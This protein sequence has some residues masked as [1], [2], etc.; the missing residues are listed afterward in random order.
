MLVK[1]LSYL[2]TELFNNYYFCPPVNHLA[3]LSS[4]FLN[5]SLLDP[6]PYNS[7]QHLK[8]KL[9]FLEH[10]LK[11]LLTQKIYQ[12]QRHL[13][14]VDMHLLNIA[15]GQHCEHNGLPCKI[16]YDIFNL[17]LFLTNNNETY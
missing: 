8:Q 2:L 5:S 17:N 15:E 11:H 9:P 1:D 3:A 14:I 4:H 7:I 13:V 16:F 10:F 6:S 12:E